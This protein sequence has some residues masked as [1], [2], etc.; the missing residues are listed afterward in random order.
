[1]AK[2][3]TLGNMYLDPFFILFGD[4]FV[5][6]CAKLEDTS[7]GIVERPRSLAVTLFARGFL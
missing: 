7:L 1:M 2:L 5:F 3:R 4:N 6:K